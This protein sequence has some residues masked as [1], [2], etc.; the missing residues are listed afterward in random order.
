MLSRNW[1][2]KIWNS[3]VKRQ[4]QL[5]GRRDTYFAEASEPVLEFMAFQELAR[6][7][8]GT[9][10]RT[11]SATTPLHTLLFAGSIRVEKIAVQ[12]FEICSEEFPEEN[13]ELETNGYQREY[14]VEVDN[15]LG[16]RGYYETVQLAMKLR[17]K[18]MNY[19]MKWLRN[20]LQRSN[21][22]DEILLD[23]M[24]KVL[25][26]E[27]KRLNFR[28]VHDLPKPR[29][30]HDYSRP[31]IHHQLSNHRNTEHHFNNGS[32]S[33]RNHYHQQQPQENG[34]HQNSSAQIHPQPQ[35]Q[36]QQINGGGH[37][38]GGSNS[39]AS[40]KSEKLELRKRFVISR[41]DPVAKSF[42]KEAA[43]AAKDTVDEV[44]TSDLKN[45]VRN[46]QQN[47][48]RNIP[49]SINSATT[50]NNENTKRIPPSTLNATTKKEPKK[51]Q[52][53]STAKPAVLPQP[54]TAAAA[55]DKSSTTISS[56]IYTQESTTVSVPSSKPAIAAAAN[57][58]EKTILS[59]NG[60]I[61]QP[62]NSTVTSSSH[63]SVSSKAYSNDVRNTGL[64]DARYSRTNRFH[65]NAPY[66]SNG[67]SNGNNQQQQ[68]GTNNIHSPFG[69]ARQFV[70]SNFNRNSN[71][72]HR[73]SNNEDNKS[74]KSSSF[75]S[76]K[77]SSN[78]AFDDRGQR[79]PQQQSSSSSSSSKP[80]RFSSSSRNQK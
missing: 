9:T 42:F 3:I 44:A 12:E 78:G 20:P 22:E 56:S 33:S 30:Y 67:Y 39:N 35:Q 72:S 68:N 69:R 4:L 73:N 58:N 79:Q 63:S 32:P 37:E 65:E 52:D 5:S 17:F 31:P 53:K 48:S 34:F 76:S 51:E 40:V 57:G 80:Q 71:R 70:N 41:N 60:G 49:S 61:A 43:A 7:E 8:E 19:F 2:Y 66:R 26:M 24:N 6:I 10:L 74:N 21:H 13:L 64:G 55:I 36:Q 77:G 62:S 29:I 15:F 27:L 47:S 50:I 11:V 23:S 54:Q 18:Y 46:M 1:Y 16:F 25:T 45:L 14:C 38:N 59:G 75:N 28:E